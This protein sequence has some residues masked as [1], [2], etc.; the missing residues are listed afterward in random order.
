MR[1][2]AH[3]EP[4][5]AFESHRGRRAD[6]VK[7]AFPNEKSGTVRVTLKRVQGQL[8]LAVSDDGKGL[9]PRRANS[10]V[11]GRL[12]RDLRATARGAG[13]ARERQQR[14]HRAFD[15]TVAFS[16]VTIYARDRLNR[17]VG[18]LRRP[19][20]ASSCN[21]PLIAEVSL[22]PFSDSS[23]SPPNRPGLGV[24]QTCSGHARILPS[25]NRTGLGVGTGYFS[26]A[27]LLRV[28]RSPG[29]TWHPCTHPASSNCVRAVQSRFL[30]VA[31][32][33]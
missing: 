9:D 32:G 31:L 1:E 6:A 19:R 12:R 26:R 25:L 13:R 7:Y 5:P 33:A 28:R 16:R 8:H 27:Q 10:G 30:L 20:L 3:H 24:K 17:S 2:E 21:A 18:S 22:W 23:A 11:G 14:Y 4:K 15:I 29:S